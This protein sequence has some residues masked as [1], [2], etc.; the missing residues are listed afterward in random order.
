M[1]KSLFILLCI[2]NLFFAQS[3]LRLPDILS[4]HM[5]LQQDSEVKFWGVGNRLANFAL[6]ETY[7]K[8]T[9]KYRFVTLKDQKIEG[10]NIRIS[11]DNVDE[12]IVI[13]GKPIEGLEIAG[14]DGNFYQASGKI[15]KK[16]KKVKNPKFV[17]FAFGNGIIGNLFDESGLPVA[18]FRTDEI[19]YDVSENNE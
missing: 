11:F 5:V 19:V 6:A 13:K 3:S 7:A 15:D 14:E 4:D 8:E 17:R 18:S 9:P 2:P 12:G 10:R 1:K 16:S